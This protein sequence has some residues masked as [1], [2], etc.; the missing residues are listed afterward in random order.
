VLADGFAAAAS[1][2]AADLVSALA[3]P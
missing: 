1:A 3:A 2:G